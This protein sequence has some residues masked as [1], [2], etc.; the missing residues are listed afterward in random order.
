MSKRIVIVLLV[1]LIIG[2]MFSSN[3]MAGPPWPAE[4][5]HPADGELCYFPWVNTSYEFVTLEGPA[6]WVAQYHSGQAQWNCH[7]TIDFT[8]PSLLSLDEIC[9]A[10]PDYCRGNGSFMWVDIPCYGNNG[11]LAKNSLMTVTPN[12]NVNI[13]CQFTLSP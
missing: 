12:G 4:V 11:E 2:A 7:T 3:A 8:D 5:L 13:G 1:T 6:T 10:A 9:T